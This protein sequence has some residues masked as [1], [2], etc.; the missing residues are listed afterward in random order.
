MSLYPRACMFAFSSHF[1]LATV[2]ALIAGV[3]LE[4]F[5]PYRRTTLISWTL[6]LLNVAS[7]LQ[8]GSALIDDF[9]LVLFMN[10]VGYGALA[11]QAVYTISDL[12]RIIGVRMF[13]IKYKPE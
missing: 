6:I 13:H 4:H 9:Y 12:K 8:T 3:S 1:L 11:H 5:Q 2:R 10:V 7:Y